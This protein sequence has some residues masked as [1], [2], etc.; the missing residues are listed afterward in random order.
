MKPFLTSLFLLLISTPSVFAQSRTYM[1]SPDCRKV[2]SL[3]FGVHRV[4]LNGPFGGHFG[5]N[6]ESIVSEKFTFNFNVKDFLNAYS[7]VTTEQNVVEHRLAVQPSVS[8]YP[9][10]A[11]H[12][13]YVNAGCG[14]FAYLNTLKNQTPV[15]DEPFLH[16]FPDAKVGFQS[17]A[18]YNFAWN[19]YLGGG[20]FLHGKKNGVAP[21]FEIG[22]KLGVK[23]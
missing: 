23:L 2:I 6:I 16:L 8:F 1:A 18:A 9:L 4:F 20:L 21:M 22:A 15:G 14:A 12:G 11:L 7:R 13:F 5:F 19:V 3:D 10:F 17:I